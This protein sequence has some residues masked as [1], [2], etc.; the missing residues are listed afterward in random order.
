MGSKLDRQKAIEVFK[1]NRSESL[2]VD[3]ALSF[4]GLDSGY[5]EGMKKYAQRLCKDGIIER[6]SR[7]F[8]RYK[9]ELK[10]V[11]KILHDEYPKVHYL[12]IYGRS[13][14]TNIEGSPA[15]G[16]RDKRDSERDKMRQLL[17][18]QQSKLDY[19]ENEGNKLVYKTSWEGRGMRIE[20]SPPDVIEITLSASNNDLDYYELWGWFNWIKGWISPIDW[21]DIDWIKCSIGINIDMKG[22][23]IEDTRKIT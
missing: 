4:L 11:D 10:E 15:I 14:G 20:V 12:K 2:N 1:H 18:M 7:G 17:D 6:T 13:K 21:Y 16:T 23:L 8:Y 9:G 5:K 19:W 22:V 3:G